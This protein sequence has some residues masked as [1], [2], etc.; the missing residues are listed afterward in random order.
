MGE[1]ADEVRRSA[2]PDDAALTDDVVAD[3]ADLETQHIRQE[4]EQTRAEMSETIDA[5]QQK[6][7]PEVIAEQAKEA[8]REAAL[9]TVQHA[10]EAVREATIGKAEEVVRNV[11]DTAQGFL[12]GGGSAVGG[13]RSTIM[14]TIRQ[15][16]LPAA[17]AG[18]GL[19]MLFKNRQTDTTSDWNR[20]GT[21]VRYPAG[22]TPYRD[23]GAYRPGD[24]LGALDR[25][26]DEPLA[27]G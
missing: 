14:E 19:F 25:L 5:I 1:A 20:Y 17:L 3:D 2:S 26:T 12:G 27:L 9:N 24:I 23:Q 10:K 13:A 6:L 18:I 7:S 8:A 4:I 16:P 22:P 21:G 11:T 15:N